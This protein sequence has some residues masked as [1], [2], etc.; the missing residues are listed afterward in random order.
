[1]P[2]LYFSN[3]PTPVKGSALQMDKPR[4]MVIRPS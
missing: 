4:G 2:S 1:L 3:I